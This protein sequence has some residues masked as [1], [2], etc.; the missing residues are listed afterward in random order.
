MTEGEALAAK[1][2]AAA[3]RRDALT[4]WG[5]EVGVKVPFSVL[6]ETPPY[7]KHFRRTENGWVEKVM[8]VNRD[9]FEKQVAIEAGATH[10]QFPAVQKIDFNKLDPPGIA[11]ALLTFQRTSKRS[12]DGTAVFEEVW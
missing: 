8:L 2:E 12:G 1:V 9:G 11:Q 7:Q 4:K 3:D 6:Y 5:R 10:F